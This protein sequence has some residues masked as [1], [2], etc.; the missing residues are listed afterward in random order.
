MLVDRFLPRYDEVERHAIEIAAPADRVYRMLR[1]LDFASSP[2]VRILFFVRGL[3]GLFSGRPRRDSLTLDDIVRGGFVVLA[4]EPGRE[5]VLGVAGRFWRLRQ[6]PIR[7]TADAFTA[8]AAPGTAKAAMNF[9]ITALSERCS[10]LVT[11]TRILC[12]D[13]DARRSFRRYWIAVCPFSGAIR[14]I[15]LRDVKRAAERS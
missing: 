12:A 11:E 4:D 6:R 7:V 8:F 2:A 13:G 9:H 14:R 15:W 1:E 5:L 10:R 3:P